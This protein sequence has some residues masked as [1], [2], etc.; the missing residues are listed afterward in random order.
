MI[1]VQSVWRSVSPLEVM[2]VFRNSWLFIMSRGKNNLTLMIVGSYEDEFVI[3]LG[4]TE[5][6]EEDY[7][8]TRV[9]LA[10]PIDECLIHIDRWMFGMKRL[11]KARRG[12][13]GGFAR[14]TELGPRPVGKEKKMLVDD[15][16]GQG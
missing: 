9:L 6:L 10:F 2:V 3:S 16:N 7:V 13:L 4:G 14:P 15:E 5:L 1:S 12:G 8:E 11:E